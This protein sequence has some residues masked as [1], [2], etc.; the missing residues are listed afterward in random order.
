MRLY[1]TKANAAFTLIEL[2]IVLIIVGLLAAGV[3]VGRD[4][5]RAAEVRAQVGQI[6]KMNTAVNAFRLK[7]NCLPGD[8]ASAVSFGLGVSNGDGENGNGNDQIENLFSG[9]TTN[10]EQSNFWYHLSGAQ[11]IEG[12]YP[13]GLVPGVNSPTPRLPSRSVAPVNPRGGLWLQNDIFYTATTRHLKPVWLIGT[14]APAGMLPEPLYGLYPAD[15][16]YALDAKFDDGYPKT[17]KMVSMIGWPLIWCSPGQECWAFLAFTTT[18]GSDSGTANQ[19]SCIDDVVTPAIYN[20]AGQKQHDF[21]D[22][23]SYCV[24]LIQAQF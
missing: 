20:I 10:L 11:M 22:V 15:D 2:S 16:S 6:E 3:L 5:I 4:L 24:P 17:G 23:A 9:T 21:D 14:A 12:K 7:Y 13:V 8:C 1:T 18:G 19:A